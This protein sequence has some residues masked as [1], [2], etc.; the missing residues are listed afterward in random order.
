M[1]IIGTLGTGHVLT[2]CRSEKPGQKT[3]KFIDRAPDGPFLKAGVIGCG[4]RGTG[5][6]LNF[7]N[8]GKNLQIIALGDAS[9]H[10]INQC[11]K[12]LKD[13]HDVVK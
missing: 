6:A 10:S 2:S 12:T 1:G 7:L 11:R 5:A 9:I 13:L 3:L 4:R 8:S